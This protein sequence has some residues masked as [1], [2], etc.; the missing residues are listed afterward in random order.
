ME[1]TVGKAWFGL[2]Q[3]ARDILI[4]DTFGKAWFGLQG[5]E[6]WFCNYQHSLHRAI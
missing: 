6:L 5:N 3:F 1:D 2:V 4:E